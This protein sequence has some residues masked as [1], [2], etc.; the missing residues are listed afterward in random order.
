M[1]MGAHSSCA[2]L[3]LPNQLRKDHLEQHRLHHHRLTLL[4]QVALPLLLPVLPQLLLPVLGQ[5][6]L[7]DSRADLQA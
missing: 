6:T 4:I 2:M 1:N 3:P 7:S 5:V